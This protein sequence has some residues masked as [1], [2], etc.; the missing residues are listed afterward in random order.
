VKLAVVYHLWNPGGI[1]RFSHALMDGLLDVDADLTIDYF[2]SDR[3]LEA[4][5]IPPFKDPTRVRTIGISDP[6]VINTNQ[7][8]PVEATGW[9]SGVHWIGRRLGKRGPVYKGVRGGYRMVLRTLQFLSRRKLGKNWNQFALQPDT[10]ATLAQYDVVYLPFPYHMEPATIGAP[11]VATFHDMNH[12]YFPANYDKR[13]IRQLEHQLAFWTARADMAVVSTRFVEQDLLVHYPGAVGRSAVVFVAPYSFVPMSRATRLAALERFGLADQAFVIYPANNS[14]HK[15]LL[16]LLKAADHLKRS[17]GCLDC[18]IVITGFGTDGLGKQ[19]WPSFEK[20]DEFLVTSSLVMGQ[21][22]HALG[23]VTDEE[24]DALTRSARLVVSTSLYE[25]GCGPALDAWQFGVPVA[26]SNIPPFIEQ[27]EALGVEAWSFDPRNHEDIARVISRALAE[28]GE[29]LAMARRSQKAIRRY[30]WK[31]A[32][33]GY[34][35]AF[36]QAVDHYRTVPS[37]PARS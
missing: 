17:S 12:L 33:E 32:A 9:R 10:L 24:V 25:A 19:R 27:L 3:L 34:L 14:T 28:R 4:D 5:R 30:T 18:P 2:V 22:V 13:G 23:F 36:E 6:D 29:S 15:N 16:G 1:T 7:D 21:D 35:R 11:V 31:Q 37:N 8:C 26:F 20:V